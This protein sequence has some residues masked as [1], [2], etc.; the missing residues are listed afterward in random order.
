MW[1]SS[2]PL[3]MFT[4]A[5]L[6][7]RSED[8]DVIRDKMHYSDRRHTEGAMSRFKI[9]RQFFYSV[10]LVEENRKTSS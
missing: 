1:P 7:E 3:N 8:A 10:M 2:P 9:R 6:S 5:S 4:I